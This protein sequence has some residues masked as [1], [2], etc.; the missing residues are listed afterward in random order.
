MRIYERQERGGMRVTPDE[1]E[2][3]MRMDMRSIVRLIEQVR[4]RA[5]KKAL[6]Q[7]WMSERVDE[8]FDVG[9]ERRTR[10]EEQSRNRERKARKKGK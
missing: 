5:E 8:D 4:A 3:V 7:E 2:R 6:G 1:V 9:R 10:R